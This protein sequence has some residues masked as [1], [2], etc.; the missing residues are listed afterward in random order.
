MKLIIETDQNIK[1]VSFEIQFESGAVTSSNSNFLTQNSESPEQSKTGEQAP[2]EFSSPTKTEHKKQEVK[3]LTSL[4]KREAK[5][6]TS[7][8]EVTV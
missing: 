5:I 7:M 6:D 8:T 1:S 4:E 3:K 2:K